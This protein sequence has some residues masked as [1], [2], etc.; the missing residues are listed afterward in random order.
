M[1]KAF[2]NGILLDG[3]A[4]PKKGLATT[5][6]DKFLRFW[7]EISECKMMIDAANR[8][9]ALDS[10]KKWFPLNKGGQ[11]RRWYGNKEYLLNWENDGAEIKQ[12][13]I[14]RYGGGSYTK[15]IRSEERYFT[16]AITWN[17]LT[18]YHAGFR[19][20]DYGALFDSAGSSMFPESTEIYY[21]LALLNTKI[22]SQIL[23]LLNPTLNFG[24]GTIAN[25]PVLIR[26]SE[27]KRVES[28]AR[29]NHSLS[30]NDWNAFETSWDFKQHPMV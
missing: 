2:K 21:L 4:S 18:S 12:A 6:N 17:A 15:E 20:S 16:D 23:N 11:F 19:I 29:N 28:L 5:D 1:L 26:N 30:C 9:N 22:V 25:I 24:A 3:L 14:D 8:M 10:C 13:V 7:F 27:K